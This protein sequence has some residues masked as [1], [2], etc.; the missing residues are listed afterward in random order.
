MPPFSIAGR[1]F[2]SQSAFIAGGRRC[3]TPSLND[4]QKARIRSHMAALRQSPM[5]TGIAGPIVV[6]VLV[7]VI[8]SAGDGNVPDAQIA[9]Q[10]LVMNQ[11]Y[12]PFNIAF[13]HVGTDR[14]DNATWFNMTM[15]SAAEREA[16][17][18]LGKATDRQLN[19]YTAR[20]GAGLLGWATFPSE[21]AGDPV[22]DGV[23]ILDTSLPGGPSVP[24]NLGKTAVH[25]V[26]HW[27]SLF[28]TF[29]N[30]CQDPGDE[31]D[32][33]PF[34]ASPNFGPANP[35]RNTCPQ[36]G[37]DP[38]TNFMDY[39]DDAGMNDFTPGQIER[40]RQQLALYRPAL[41]GAP[42]VTTAR[43]TATRTRIAGVN[44][45]TGDF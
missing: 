41:G 16:K 17:T 22:R 36:P 43:T 11:C 20:I 2:P 9:Q 34:E 35:A 3:G 39:T 27:L 31:V 23:V 15:G 30:A 4:F 24:Y 6:P 42:P 14:T 21:L 1:E 13:N 29:E 38:T 44:L 10:L 37:N 8:H 33:T 25:E 18:A 28:H 26:G 7:H 5:A 45:V 19:F 40:I 12:S 32:D